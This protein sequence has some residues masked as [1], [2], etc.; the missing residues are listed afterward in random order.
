[1]GKSAIDKNAYSFLKYSMQ[2]GYYRQSYFFETKS[3]YNFGPETESCRSGRSGQTRNL[4]YPSGY[5]GFESLTLRLFCC[6]IYSPPFYIIYQPHFSEYSLPASKFSGQYN[7]IV[8]PRSN[9][10]FHQSFYQK[11][12]LSNIPNRYPKQNLSHN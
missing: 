10:T 12:R 9:H 4:L 1:M 3:F 8:L 6:K 11:A 5:R 7:E 2:V